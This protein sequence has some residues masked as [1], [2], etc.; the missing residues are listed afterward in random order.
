MEE[1]FVGER[2]AG[3]SN[4]KRHRRRTLF[5]E[6]LEQSTKDKDATTRLT[7]LDYGHFLADEL[8]ENMKSVPMNHMITDVTEKAGEMSQS[9]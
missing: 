6:E 3:G 5:Y 9:L 4:R 2:T 8:E 1:V 7:D